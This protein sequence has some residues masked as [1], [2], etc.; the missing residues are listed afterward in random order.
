[1]SGWFAVTVR[2]GSSQ[3]WLST[4]ADG[5][6]AVVE[7]RG[8]G[9]E[10]LL[11][12]QLLVAQRAVLVAERGV[13]LLR[14]V[15]DLP[16]VRHHRPH[17]VFVYRTHVSGH[18]NDPLGSAACQ[19]ASRPYL[20]RPGRRRGDLPTRQRPARRGGP[21]RTA[22]PRCAVRRWSDA[23]SS[24]ATSS[25]RRLTPDPPD[26]AGS[27][28]RPRRP[29]DLDVVVVVTGG[30]GAIEP[31][32]ALGDPD[33]ASTGRRWRS[34]CATPTTGDRPQRP[35]R[36]SPPST[37]LA[38][39]E[40]DDEVPVSR[41]GPPAVRRRPVRLWLAAARR[42]RGRRPPAQA[43][44]RRAGGRR[45]PGRRRARHLHRRR[46]RPRAA[47]SS[48]RPGCTT[49]SGTATPTTGFEHHGFLNVLLATRAAL[50]GGRRRRRGRGARRDA[51]AR[52]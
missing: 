33:R 4:I 48:A 36:S 35:P 10:A 24:S 23:G 42:A 29:D 39:G 38:S 15:A 50:D 40:L 43:A 2:S 46:P 22:A 49:R 32:V 45:L 31:A 25:P 41:R 28:A 47:A 1:M 37:L 18:S 17:D 8:V 5:T 3:T 34:P 52:R 30:A 20:A 19:P 11:A 6:P 9:G 27:P 12:H 7:Q 16:V 51:T 26:D 13:P 14:D 44:H 21:R